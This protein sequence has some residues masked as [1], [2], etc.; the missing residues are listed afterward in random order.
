[1]RLWAGQTVALFGEQ[2]T[3]LALPLTAI[4]LLNA[5]ASQVGLLNALS[6]LPVIFVTL[7]A[8]VLAD[9]LRRRRLLIAANVGR[10]VILAL[11]P[12]FA[13]AGHLSIGLLFLVAFGTGL[14]TAQFDVA[15]Q[16]YLPSLIDRR[17][18]VEGNS[19]LQS[20]QSIAQ[21]AG[22]GLSGVLIQVFTAPTAILFNSVG[23]L[24]SVVSLLSIRATEPTRIAPRRS[25]RAEIMEGLRVTLAHPVLR[26]LVAESAWFNLMWD[27]V[28]VVI[29][30]YGIRVL[31]LGAARLGLVIAAGSIG[32]FGGSVLAGS[33]GRRLG[34]SRAMAA[35]MLLAC[36]ATIALPAATGP[37][38]AIMAQLIASYVVN[39][40]GI[41]VFNVHSVALRQSLV[42]TEL[43]GRVSASYRFASFA[44]IPIGG[45]AGGVL[46][47][48]LG[49]RTALAVSV[50][51]LVI[52]AVAF[53]A[54]R[55]VRQANRQELRPNATVAADGQKM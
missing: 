34:T 45:F 5:S 8:G 25:I 35:G 54:S 42:P 29:P 48:R 24:V 33:I 18:L 3:L 19:K 50:I 13:W 38:W 15:Y 9:R 32:A 16:A 23:Y 27:V 53:F 31:H 14:F 43:I 1:M 39:G 4:Q 30:I 12:I 11:V 10:I 17:L 7:L 20:S 28:L 41:T 36:V 51:G 52:G 44:A 2:I 47:E 55:A 26:V 49:S 46:A 37:T 21:T 40:F 6:Y 22:Q